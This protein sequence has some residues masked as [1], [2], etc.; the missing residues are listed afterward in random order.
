MK[1]LSTA[2]GKRDPAVLAKYEVRYLIIILPR[3]RRTTIAA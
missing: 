2:N 3:Q 1:M